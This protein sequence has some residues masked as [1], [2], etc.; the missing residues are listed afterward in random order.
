MSI[1]FREQRARLEG[2]CGVEEAESLHAWMLEQTAPEVDLSACEHLHTAVL[3]VLLVAR[4]S[5][6]VLPPGGFLGQ[7]LGQLLAARARGPAR[8]VQAADDQEREPR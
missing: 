3:Q 8:V 7:H 6:V 4:P 1:V 5:L 2:H